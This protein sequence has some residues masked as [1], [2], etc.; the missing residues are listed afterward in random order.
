MVDRF[1][2]KLAK[3]HG[4]NLALRLDNDQAIEYIED[5]ID[6]GSP[7]VAEKAAFIEHY[8]NLLEHDNEFRYHVLENG[9]STS[10][11]NTDPIE[12][13][14]LNERLSRQASYSQLISNSYKN[15]PARMDTLN[16]EFR[17]KFYNE[18]FA[19]FKDGVIKST[20]EINKEI[21]K[22]RSKL[23][24]EA[25]LAQ[26]NLDERLHKTLAESD[27]QLLDSDNA[28]LAADFDTVIMAEN[29]DIL[30]AKHYSDSLVKVGETYQMKAEG[31]VIQS[32][33]NK[34]VFPDALA[35][36]SGVLKM[37]IEATPL[38]IAKQGV[39][40]DV[41]SLAY[42][43]TG[44]YLNLSTFKKVIDKL[45]LSTGIANIDVI[46]EKLRYHAEGTGE[47]A[48][49]A[50]ALYTRYFSS[51]PTMVDG[52]L[53][54]SFY[55]MYKQQ[56]R[57][58]Q[59]TD[60]T[61]GVLLHLTST[62]FNTV[63][64]DYLDYIDGDVSPKRTGSTATK[65]VLLENISNTVKSRLDSILTQSEVTRSADGTPTKVTLFK[66]GENW[67]HIFIK[68]DDGDWIPEK[69]PTRSEYTKILN[70]YGVN[71]SSVGSLDFFDV[72]L[73]RNDNSFQKLNDY[74][75]HLV[76]ATDFNRDLSESAVK[77]NSKGSKVPEDKQAELMKKAAAGETISPTL[78]GDAHLDTI[79]DVLNIINVVK[80]TD[81]Q[82]NIDGKSVPSSG[83]QAPIHGLPKRILEL[84]KLGDGTILNTN[85]FVMDDSQYELERF[86]FKDG[87]KGV[88]DEKAVS[89]TE[90]N[91][92][93]T[94]ALNI[95]GLFGKQLIKSG[96]KQT[97][98]DFFV[99]SDKS[100]QPVPKINAKGN[101]EFLPRKRKGKT[102][103]Y[104]LDM[105]ALHKE[106]FDTVG[107]YYRDIAKRTLDNWNKHLLA[108]GMVDPGGELTSLEALDAFLQ[109][110]ELTVEMYQ[111][112]DLVKHL[113][114][115][116]VKKDGKNFIRIR[117]DMMAFN[118]IYSTPAR[119][120][121]FLK[122]K[123]EQFFKQMSNDPSS[124]I[125]NE[126]TGRG[127][128]FEISDDLN[129]AMGKRFDKKWAD[130]AL[131]ID[132]EYNPLLLGY[133]MHHN[134]ISNNIMHLHQ[135]SILQYTPGRNEIGEYPTD[136]VVEHPDIKT[137]PVKTASGNVIV[138][139]A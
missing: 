8:N 131:E 86:Y 17:L 135:G 111:E 1:I 11:S 4:S 71:T 80:E 25:K 49:L 79:R 67:A 27:E 126:T 114:Y 99:P 69:A 7:N 96:F 51:N 66:E 64:Y 101:A 54:H 116:V 15:R 42:K 12:A 100:R 109:K 105:E 118:H 19:D 36:M 93:A 28:D 21:G 107:R 112:K 43:S 81:R 74:I 24:E 124:A 44:M 83:L 23:V 62:I 103:K 75:A 120:K 14:A 10:V 113:E 59:N 123:F 108:D 18:V 13:A 46:S 91:D 73:E 85:L 65:T 2:V 47:V 132:G 88:G 37:H 97:F 5:I 60:S 138:R 26:A 38:S 3:E 63:N 70:L 76:N 50:A 33:Q 137:T 94:A 117:Q 30:I 48:D 32:W 52:E 45:G 87:Y 40:D 29:F 127:I 56:L 72:Y 6:K 22:M 78:W 68:D 58:G 139:P 92:A 77:I 16:R 102:N 119:T 39:K 9:D 90:L 57:Q 31:K 53:V 125:Q 98:L 128:D 129:G 82:T 55:S 136:M 20:K 61:E 121:A 130:G 84:A 106:Y 110:V 122:H 95:N 133:F 134:T 34:D 104:S 89:H 41:G 115:A 35:N